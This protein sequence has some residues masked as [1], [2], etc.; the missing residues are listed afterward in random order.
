P[1]FN[2]AGKVFWIDA[3]LADN[4]QTD[5]VYDPLKYGIDPYQYP[6]AD[7][8]SYTDRPANRELV[9]S[10]EATLTLSYDSNI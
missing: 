4:P 7:V 1:N 9:T 2:K 5:N 6:T 10:K 3:G 8:P